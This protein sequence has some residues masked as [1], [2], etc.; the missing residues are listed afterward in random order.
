[1]K[2][3]ENDQQEKLSEF[4]KERDENIEAAQCKLIADSEAEVL[5]V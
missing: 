3:L 1:L 4:A 5:E 2:R